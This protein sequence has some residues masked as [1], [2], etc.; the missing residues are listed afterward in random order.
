MDS[1]P[2]EWFWKKGMVHFRT[3]VRSL[4]FPDWGDKKDV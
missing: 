2:L 1:H 3:K 4:V